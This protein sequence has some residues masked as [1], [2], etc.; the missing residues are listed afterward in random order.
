MTAGDSMHQCTCVGETT[1]QCRR[2][3]IHNC[4]FTTKLHFSLL[5][6]PFACW[7]N[8]ASIGAHSRSICTKRGDDIAIE[9]QHTLIS[10]ELSELSY[11]FLSSTSRLNTTWANDISYTIDQSV[12]TKPSGAHN[13]GWTID[14][15]E[16]TFPDAFNAPIAVNDMPWK[17]PDFHRDGFSALAHS[18]SHQHRSP[19]GQCTQRRNPFANT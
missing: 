5:F 15:A 14:V 6:F 2:L 10:N 19:F 16:E 11:F 18:R 1:D 3:V 12:E 17:R 7:I 13:L 4:D 8:Y 9:T